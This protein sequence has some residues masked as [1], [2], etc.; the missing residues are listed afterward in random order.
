MDEIHAWDQPHI[1]FAVFTGYDYFGS[2]AD[3]AVK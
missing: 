1:Y 2:Q 3:E